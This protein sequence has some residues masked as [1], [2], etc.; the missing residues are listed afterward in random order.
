MF[1]SYVLRTGLG[2]G[3]VCKDKK[4]YKGLSLADSAGVCRLWCYAPPF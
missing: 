2:F 1:I 4:I 3:L